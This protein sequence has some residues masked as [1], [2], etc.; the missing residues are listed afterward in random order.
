L[1][2]AAG[3]LAGSTG[4]LAAP[5]TNRTSAVDAGKGTLVFAGNISFIDVSNRVVSVEGGDRFRNRTGVLM[6]L[7]RGSTAGNIKY[8]NSPSVKTY[9]LASGS[10]DFAVPLLCHIISWMDKDSKKIQIADLVNGMP[11]EVEYLKSAGD[12]WR[13]TAIVVRNPVQDPAAAPA[14]VAAPAK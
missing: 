13:A 14:P 8:D 4:L 3:T 10:R 12:G 1:I 9:E 6:T 7:N 11:V 5:S 2:L